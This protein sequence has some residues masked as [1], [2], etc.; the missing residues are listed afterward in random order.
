M[1]T[2]TLSAGDN[3]HA[4]T[5]LKITSNLSAVAT[6]YMDD[7]GADAGEVDA[8]SVI[9]LVNSGTAEVVVKDKTGHW[10]GRVPA[11]TSAWLVAGNDENWKVLAAAVAFERAAKINDPAGGATTDAEARTAIASIIDALENAG[12]SASA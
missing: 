7:I 10:V 8:G 5:N 12:I 11:K 2:L 1:A 6:V 3:V 4:D 9:P